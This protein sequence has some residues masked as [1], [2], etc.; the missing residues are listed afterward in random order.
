MF[1]SLDAVPGRSAL[2]TPSERAEAGLAHS[3]WVS[4]AKTGTPHCAGGQAWPRYTVRTDQLLEF[5]DPP[6][7]R[8]HFRKRQLDAQEAMAMSRLDRP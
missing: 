2:I 7:I 3:C 4:F 6:A 1:D 5:G 8:T